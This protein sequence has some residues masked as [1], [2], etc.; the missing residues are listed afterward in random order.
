[1]H[2]ASRRSNSFQTR[3]PAPM[4]LIYYMEVPVHNNVDINMYY[5]TI[6]NNEVIE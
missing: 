3:D 5:V 2:Y 4:L 1:M 6:D